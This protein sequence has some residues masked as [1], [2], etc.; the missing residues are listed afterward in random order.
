MGFLTSCPVPLIAAA[1]LLESSVL[2]IDTHL[3]SL[4]FRASLSIHMY[5]PWQA[6]DMRSWHLITESEW[7]REH[8]AG[9]L[10]EYISR[11]G[12]GK[13]HGLSLFCIKQGEE[14]IR[15][16]CRWIR[17]SL[18]LPVFRVSVSVQRPGSCFARC[19]FFL[20]WSSFCFTSV[21]ATQLASTMGCTWKGSSVGGLNIARSRTYARHNPDLEMFTSLNLQRQLLSTSIMGRKWCF[22]LSTPPQPT[23]DP[24]SPVRATCFQK[25]AIL[26][27]KQSS[28]PRSAVLQPSNGW[29]NHI[30]ACDHH[31]RGT[32][33][34]RGLTIGAACSRRNTTSLDAPASPTAQRGG[35]MG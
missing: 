5:A 22:P 24:P 31:Q 10:G 14:P 12:G 29:T 2:G 3:R 18:S 26:G 7:L 25:N 4:L 23:R 6:D 35:I 8:M 30:A 9:W 15:R 20:P 19:F 27:R 33:S 21:R 34:R 1:V 11:W 16:C 13:S 17:I 32:R 28:D